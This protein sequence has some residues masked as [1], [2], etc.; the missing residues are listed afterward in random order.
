M[1]ATGAFSV[2]VAEP[3]MLTV[4]ETGLGAVHESLLQSQVTDT[5]VTAIVLAV[6]PAFEAHEA[7]FVSIVKVADTSE[8]I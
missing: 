1:L 5:R 4:V 2:G 6:L 3:S 8:L 7:Y